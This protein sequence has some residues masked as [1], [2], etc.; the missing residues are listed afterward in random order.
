MGVDG[1]QGG[2]ML[3]CGLYVGHRAADSMH[4]CSVGTRREWMG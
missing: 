3:F 2:V 1:D 4:M